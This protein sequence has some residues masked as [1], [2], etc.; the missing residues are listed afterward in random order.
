MKLVYIY[1]Q[2]H[3][4]FLNFDMSFGDTFVDLSHSCNW[5]SVVV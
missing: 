5:L 2:Y 4:N 1:S 3:L